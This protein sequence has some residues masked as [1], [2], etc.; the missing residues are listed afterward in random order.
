[1]LFSFSRTDSTE[2]TSI[3]KDE[4]ADDT[5]R[6]RNGAQHGHWSRFLR[7][8]ELNNSPSYATLFF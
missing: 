6:R 8:C 7:L 2:T 3:H 4:D 1:M 5:A